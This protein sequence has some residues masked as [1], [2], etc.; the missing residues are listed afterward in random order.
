[1]GPSDRMLALLCCL[2][3]G[4]EAMTVKQLADSTAQ[5][6]STAYRHLRQLLAWGL[7]SE[8]ANGRYAPGAQAVRLQQGFLR[9]NELMRWASPVLMELTERTQ[10]SSALLVALRDHALCVEMID[11]PQ[12]LRCCYRQ[13]QVQPLVKGASARALLAWMSDAEREMALAL[14]DEQERNEALKGL[15]DI[16][17]HGF[18]VSLG[19]IDE[20]VWGASAPVLT[21]RGQLKAVVSVMAP[22]S[23]VS[24]REEWLA[25]QTRDSAQ[26]LGELLQ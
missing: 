7:V 11:S 13:G 9:S 19:E 17:E 1:M 26:R 24:G 15:A 3:N 14:R 23:R 4:D 10:E 20:G 5:P 16:R 8:R 6:V 12:P 25:C 21:P 22:Q 2:A 18:A